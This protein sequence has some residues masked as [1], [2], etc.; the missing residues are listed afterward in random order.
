MENGDGLVCLL[1][2]SLADV[3]SDNFD[4]HENEICTDS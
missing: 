4:S 3:E 1:C 2:H